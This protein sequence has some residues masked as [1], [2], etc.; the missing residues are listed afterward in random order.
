MGEYVKRYTDRVHDVPGQL[1]RL[2]KLIRDLDEK[3]VSLQAD[4]NI[5]CKQHLQAALASR[6]RGGREL[7]ASKRQKLDDSPLS[8]EIDAGMQKVI[9]YAE[10][11]LRIA[12]QVYDLVDAHIRDL[13]KDLAQFD[14]ELSEDKGKVGLKEGET[15]R[16][17][18]GLDSGLPGAE[19][20]GGQQGAEQRP[21]RRYVRRK[22]RAPS[23][24]AENE[25]AAEAAAAGGAAA[26]SA[27]GGPAPGPPVEND[28]TEPVYCLCN[29]V[30]FGEMIACDNPECLIEWF[31]YDCVG[32][33]QQPKGK[34]YCPECAKH[35]HK[36]H[37]KKT[38]GAKGK[39]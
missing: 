15:A 2:F 3:Q 6:G 9:S 8:A 26:G 27:D 14:K 16:R 38:G 31:H 4:V 32:I 18:L 36:G 10:E 28:G 7:P 21:K 1:Q 11:K 33:T 37:P 25:G 23:A 5:K 39:S 20:A 22:G 24:E 19:A 12:S 34:W 35:Q 30:S 13:D 17:V 29:R